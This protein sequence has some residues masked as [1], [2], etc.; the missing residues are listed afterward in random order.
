MAAAASFLHQQRAAPP[1]VFRIVRIAGAPSQRD[2]RHTHRRPAAEDGE[3]QA[4]AA[5]G[6]FVGTLLNRRKKFSVVCRAISSSETPRVSASTLAV[7]TTKDGSLRLPRCG[8]GARY[9]A[10]VSTM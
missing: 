10:S 1:A 7:S 5:S 4:H 2:A 3:S 6:R 9:G 8:P